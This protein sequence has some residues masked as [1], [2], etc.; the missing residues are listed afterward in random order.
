MRG[1]SARFGVVAVVFLALVASGC[2]KTGSKDEDQDTG[3]APTADS[4]GADPGA[5]DDEGELEDSREGE[6]GG[7]SDTTVEDPGATGDGVGEDAPDGAPSP[8]PQLVFTTAPPELA[9]EGQAFSYDARISEAGDPVF[10]LVSGPAGME[11]DQN[12]R[13]T[14]TPGEGDA[15]SV[16]VSIGATLGEEEATQEFSIDVKA[17]ER[18]AVT[19]LGS[20]GGVVQASTGDAADVAGIGV[21]IPPGALKGD[22]E[23]S[24]DLLD[25]APAVGAAAP[26]ADVR[27]V[28]LGPAGTTFA[29][30]VQV[31]IP[32]GAGVDPATLSAFTFQEQS[33][34]WEPL[35]VVD[36]DVEN[37]LATVETSHFSVVGFYPLESTFTVGLERIE[38]DACARQVTVSGVLESGLQSLPVT[39]VKELSRGIKQALENNDVRS[40]ADMLDAPQV[41]AIRAGWTYTLVNAASGEIVGKSAM[42]ASVWLK[43][44]DGA[45]TSVAVVIEDA[46][47]TPLS[48]RDFTTLDEGRD[49]IHAVLEGRSVIGRFAAPAE[50]RL[51]G[52]ARVRYAH[53]RGTY[54]PGQPMPGLGGLS[55]E[56]SIWGDSGE[57][58]PDAVADS[59]DTDCD[60][61]DDAVD[62]DVDPAAPRISGEPAGTV[63]SIVGLPVDL[64][65]S[66]EGGDPAGIEWTLVAG[67]GALEGSAGAA[68]FTAGVKGRHV[69]SCGLETAQPYVFAVDAVDP[70]PVNTP[71]ACAISVRDPRVQPGEATSISG[72]ASDAESGPQLLRIEIG[73]VVDGELTGGDLS[74]LGAQVS[75]ARGAPTAGFVGVRPGAY[76]VGCRAD[77]GVEKGPVSSAVIEVLPQSVNEPPKISSFAPYGVTLEVGQSA[78]FTVRAS[79]PQGEELTYVWLPESVVASEIEGG[80]RGTYGAAAAGSD[81]VTVV[82]SD[83]TNDPLRRTALVTIVSDRGEN[84]GDGDGVPASDD[85]DDDERLVRPGLKEVCDGLDNDCSGV[86]DDNL[87][88]LDEDGQSNCVDADDDGDGVD[89]GADNCPRDANPEQADGD[90]DGQ[91]DACDPDTCTPACAGNCGPDGCG[92]VCGLCAAGERCEGGTCQATGCTRTCGDAECGPDGCGGVCGVCAE[93]F[94]CGEGGQCESTC[95]RICDEGFECGSDGCGGF[96]GQCGEG[97]VCND[98][99]CEESRETRCGNSTDDDRDGHTDCEDQDC[100]EAPECQPV[101]GCVGEADKAA[102]GDRD[103]YDLGVEAIKLCG[104]SNKVEDCLPVLLEEE[105]GRSLSGECS[106][107]YVRYVECAIG[108]CGGPCGARGGAEAPNADAGA[109]PAGGEGGSPDSEACAHCLAE[110]CEED[111]A[112]CAGFEPRPREQDCDNDTD[113]D[114]DGRIDCDDNDCRGEAVCC[115]PSCEGLDCGDDG[116]GG[117]CGGCAEG[118]RCNAGGLC[119]DTAGACLGEADLAVTEVFKI[120]L[121]HS[122]LC[123]WRCAFDYLQGEITR[124]E[125]FA[126]LV[127]CVQEEARRVSGG[128][129][130][131]EG[132]AGCY[133]EYDL[134]GTERCALQCSG[135]QLSDACTACI[136]AACKEALEACSGA[137][138]AVRERCDNEIDDDKDGATDCLDYDCKLDGPCCEGPEAGCDQNLDCVNEASCEVSSDGC[139]PFECVEGTCTQV[140]VSCDDGN[141]CTRDRCSPTGTAVYECR[142]DLLYGDACDDDDPCT[143]ADRCEAGLCVPGGS[144]DCDDGDPCTV[145]GCDGESGECEHAAV[146]CGEGEVCSLGECVPDAPCS[147]DGD[148]DDGDACTTDLCRGGFCHSEPACDD[149]DACTVD[150]CADDEGV[151]RCSFEKQDGLPC[152]DGDLCTVDDACR[153]G[154]CFGGGVNPCEDGNPCTTGE[155]SGG[156][157]YQHVELCDDLNECTEDSCDP[158]AGCVFKP[159]DDDDECPSGGFCS[160]EGSRT[161]LAAR[162]ATGEMSLKSVVVVRAMVDCGPRDGQPADLSSSCLQRVVEGL[163]LRSHGIEGVTMGCVGCFMQLGACAVSACHGPCSNTDDPTIGLCGNCLAASGCSEALDDCA[164]IEVGVGDDCNADEACDDGDVCTDD[165]CDQGICRGRYVRCDDGNPCTRDECQPGRGCVSEAIEGCRYERFCAN[166]VDDDED[167]RTDCDDHDCSDTLDCL[168]HAKAEVGPDGGR[169][170]LVDGEG[171]LLASLDVPAGALSEATEII[172]VQT[173]SRHAQDVRSYGFV[174]ELR[175]D[176]TSFSQPAILGLIQG[177]APEDAVIHHTVMGS[178]RVY[179]ALDSAVVEGLV[180]A[181]IEHF[182]KAIVGDPPCQSDADCEDGNDCTANTCTAGVCQ[183]DEQALKGR[184][185][186]GESRCQRPGTCDE[187]GRCRTSGMEVDCDDGNRCT[188][189]TCD[190]RVGCVHHPTHSQSCDDGD[191]CTLDDKCYGGVCTGAREK[192]CDDSDDCTIDRCDPEQG[193]VFESAC[194]EGEVCVDRRCQPDH[195]CS[196]PSDCD[197]GDVCT[198]DICFAGQC[199]HRPVCDDGDPC[200]LDSCDAGGECASDAAAADGQPCDDGSLCTVGEACSAGACEG[201]EQR[202]CEDGNPCTTGRCDESQGCV[203]TLNECD[204]GL[205]CTTDRCDAAKGGCYSEPWDCSEGQRCIEP[206][207][208]CIDDVPCEGDEDCPTTDLCAPNTCVEGK[209]QPVPVECDDGNVCTDDGCAVP[210]G[211]AVGVCTYTFNRAGCDD[212]DPCTDYSNC[213]GGDCKHTGEKSCND[214]D[215]CTTDLCDP[216]TGGCVNEPMDCGEGQVCRSG[217][218]VGEAVCGTSADCDDGDLCTNDQCYE[219]GC[220]YTPRCADSNPCTVDECNPENG[221][222]T[223]TTEPDWSPCD[224]NDRCTVDDICFGGKCEGD[225]LSCDD[226]NA[227][228]KDTD[229]NTLLGCYSYSERSCDDR[230]P[231]TIDSCDREIGC[232]F[233]LK[234]SPE[235]ASMRFCDNS[236][237]RQRLSHYDDSGGYEAFVANRCRS[238]CNSSSDWLSCIQTCGVTEGDRGLGNKCKGCYGA[239]AAC[240]LP[241]C[242][243][244]CSG[245]YETTPGTACGDCIAQSGCAQALAQCSGIGAAGARET[246]CDDGFDNDS[247]LQRDCEDS[248]CAA[249]AACTG[250]ADTLVLNEVDFT[251]PGGD[252]AEFVELFNPSE[253]GLATA[254]LVL[255]FRAGS[256]SSYDYLTV[257]LAPALEISPG[258]YLV[259]GAQAVLDTLGADVAKVAF[260]TPA[261]VIR[262]PRVDFG[263]DASALRLLFRGEDVDGFHAA[264][265][266]TGY[267]EGDVGPLDSGAGS[268]SRCPNGKDSDRN[269]RDFYLTNGVTPGAENACKAVL[270]PDDDG[271][272]LPADCDPYDPSVY[273]DAPELCDLEDND[274]DGEVDEECTGCPGDRD[275]DYVPDHTDNCPDVENPT[276]EDTDLDGVGDACDPE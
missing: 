34:A 122:T 16:D 140:P 32:F 228:T 234:A 249:D 165:F 18:I 182:S 106:G 194:G 254:G 275:C 80:S 94:E 130:F 91:G 38:G 150:R 136:A 226:G 224:D 210:F 217:Y 158:G 10:A 127:P 148:C 90:G 125:A 188:T 75:H 5:L 81:E 173:D 30:P 149:G 258:G 87:P 102:I 163:G 113:D 78:T 202:A 255:R 216:E 142:H 134:C 70:P 200:T 267:G 31:Q 22:V 59:P 231:C 274:C 176:G 273:P 269:N 181:G 97:E 96:C 253:S 24:L 205:A 74:E 159:R 183:V 244:A 152:D 199:S 207:G 211:S 17:L 235:C 1:G 164:G 171:V 166:E 40:V 95:E 185:C 208:D 114:G 41:H 61:V 204:D 230:N 7:L 264:Q 131:S 160:D 69:V 259:V 241:R 169:V 58:F 62:D 45:G 276:Q 192:L 23:I 146:E 238:D 71:P 26:G 2:G 65:C 76:A 47:G 28:V 42:A 135:D 184:P 271:H 116:C 13:L 126:C 88:D 110:D 222:C 20:E 9:V 124:A 174:Y 8:E 186:Q 99:R 233:V 48:R 243:A 54:A 190:R 260:E 132:C 161:F 118:Q 270:D 265:R 12:G 50:G 56:I 215:Q 193:C 189:D 195:G 144:P 251:Q 250:A 141:P 155:C 63:P 51:V 55:V 77:D 175:P 139:N 120:D 27:A 261:N 177:D 213:V 36:V 242:Q 86:T 105:L 219:G 198:S 60:Q 262:N 246:V 84:D 15:G 108:R 248:D 68:T 240:V 162:N 82:V 85:C 19:E 115:V 170:E 79:D 232:V 203:Q 11:I 245:G 43:G 272:Q 103:V 151:A 168:L 157:C 229:C 121:R 263:T 6:D 4:G 109:T 252:V 104:N 37:R 66:V 111:L 117:S 237:D 29:S 64:S 98:G 83:G 196:L 138:L 239:Y 57:R 153:L 21:L 3:G 137:P 52:G 89:D 35:R 112:G 133:A 53:A 220:R 197:D 67:Q 167:G 212:G 187:G 223:K 92:G 25:S 49:Y 268:V 218:C 247:D 172:I 129:E 266:V 206:Q 73:L 72:V 191:R 227:C 214:G 100:E 44:A 33:G 145:D 180:T 107:C 147:E 143:L 257:D 128:D 119:L 221:R 123:T 14:W 179:E 201:G 225:A 39:A 93:G 46:T 178:D 101:V 209:C 154:V 236:E 256:G 156:Q